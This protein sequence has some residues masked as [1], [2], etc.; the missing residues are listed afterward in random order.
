MCKKV[1]EIAPKGLKKIR[2]AVKRTI[3]SNFMSLTFSARMELDC[4]EVFCTHWTWLFCACGV[5]FARAACFPSELGDDW[6]VLALKIHTSGPLEYLNNVDT[7][8]QFE[9]FE[10]F[11]AIGLIRDYL[12]LS[13]FTTMPRLQS[14]MPCRIISVNS[15]SIE[16]KQ[17]SPETRE[18]SFTLE[19]I[20][21]EA[22]LGAE[23][24]N[25]DVNLQ[26]GYLNTSWNRFISGNST[27]VE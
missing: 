20:Y 15:Q 3:V 8:E 14:I 11:W 17:F 23:I 19:N 26:K 5:H 12:R 10:Q 22:R 16:S 4:F 2:G 13:C 18:T 6:L 27:V 21:T 25:S 9:Q 24:L 7:F 1:R